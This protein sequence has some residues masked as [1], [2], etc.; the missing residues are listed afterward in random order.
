[1]KHFRR[2]AVFGVCGLLAAGA[3]LPAPNVEQLVLADDDDTLVLLVHGAGPD[4]DPTVWADATA[5]D[6]TTALVEDRRAAGV[7]VHAWDWSAR[8][9]SR[10]LAT[11]AAG[12]EG[13][14]IADVIADSAVQHLHIVAHSLGAQV[15]VSLLEALNADGS[16]VT[17]HATLLDP[18]SLF[19]VVDCSTATVC[20][21][22]RNSD[23]G[24]P[25][26]DVPLETAYNRDVTSVRPAAWLERGHWWPT[27]AWR[28][29][30]AAR[31]QPGFSA[32][33]EAGVDLGTLGR[34]LAR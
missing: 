16:G 12:D 32:S 24:A 11:S 4:E 2:I 10:E 19:G 6:I 18:F 23:D 14:A 13:Q 31:D 5:A 22:W 34:L 21:S 15:A 7:A 8:S 33:V 27:E 3:C 9:A 25:G 1:M 26:S 29:T 17:T 28:Q 30:I 20:E